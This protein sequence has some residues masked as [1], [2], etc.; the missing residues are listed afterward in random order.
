L[1]DRDD[2]GRFVKGHKPF[3]TKNKGGRPKRTTE[4]KYLRVLHATVKLEDWKHIILTAMARAKSGDSRARQWLSDYLLGKPAQ[5]ITLQTVG[6]VRI[7]LK[8]SDAESE[9]ES[10]DFNN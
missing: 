2:K 6:D 9:N 10:A 5:Q 8:W 7:K 4:E 1:A 3:N